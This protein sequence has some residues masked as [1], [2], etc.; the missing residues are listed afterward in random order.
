MVIGRWLGAIQVGERERVPARRASPARARVRRAGARRRGP[1]SRWRAGRR[2]VEQLVAL[3]AGVA[4]AALRVPDLE[5]RAATRRAVAVAGDLHR[6]PLPDHVPPE[7]DPARPAELEPQAARLG[8]RGGEGASQRDGL[9]DEEQRAG[10]PGQRRQPAQPVPHPLAGDRRVAAVRQVDHQQVHRAGGEQ[11]AGHRE[12]L[13][14]VLRGQD[15]QPLGVDATA[16]GLD[17]VEGAGEVQP[18][19][20]RPA[21]L[22]LRGDPQRDGRAAGRGLPAERDRGGARQAARAEDR[23]QRGEPRRDDAAVQVRGGLGGAVAG[24]GASGVGASSGASSGSSGSGI[25]ARASAPST[26]W[27]SRSPPR[28]GAAEPQRAWS[29]ASA[30]ETSDVRAIGRPI[31]ERMFYSVKV[32]P[33]HPWHLSRLSR[34]SLVRGALSAPTSASWDARVVQRTVRCLHKPPVQQAGRLT[35]EPSSVVMPTALRGHAG[36]GHPPRAPPAWRPSPDGTGIGRCPAGCPGPSAAS[37]R[38]RPR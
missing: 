12:R 19:D 32:L 1:G 20:D 25:G 28:R 11:R 35:P 30:S 31:L 16:H 9:E 7:A 23:V 26:G 38:L 13:L 2:A 8:D 6:A 3:Q 29:V 21:G 37:S 15:D 5:L 14:E 34:A 24:D 22:C 18:R 27:S 17:G 36:V 33:T 10:P 4:G